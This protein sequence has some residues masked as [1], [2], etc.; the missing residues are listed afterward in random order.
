[1]DGLIEALTIFRKY[2]NLEWPTNCSHDVLGIAGVERE[3]VSDE[4]HARLDELGFLWD[5]HEGHY[6]SFKYGSC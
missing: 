6:Y 4:D 5:E 2:A 3:Q 1:M